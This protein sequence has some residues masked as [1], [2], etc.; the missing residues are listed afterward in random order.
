ML[1]WYGGMAGTPMPVLQSNGRFPACLRNGEQGE[2]VDRRVD[3]ACKLVQRTFKHRCL[4]NHCRRARAPPE[5][6]LFC[7]GFRTA[8]TQVVS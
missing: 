6:L 1:Q 2:D 4:R 5:E 7:L 8:I 3:H